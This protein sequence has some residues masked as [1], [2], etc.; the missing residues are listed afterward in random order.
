MRSVSDID[1]VTVDGFGTLLELVDP[2]DALR[3][4]LAR[5]GVERDADAVRQA[6][7]AE[8]GHYR[9]RSLAGRDAAGLAAL[10]EECVGVFLST[11]E[12]DLPPAS[13][14]DAF[15]A[16]I[17]FTLADG[18]GNALEQIAAAGVALA[19][20]AN[21]DSSLHDHLGRSGVAHRFQVV[22]PSAEAGC[23]KPDPRIFA[24]ALERL[25]VEPG[26]AVHIGD[27]ESDRQGAAAAGMRFEPVPLATLP[28]RLGLGR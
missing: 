28:A 26:R 4:A 11:L 25:A 21:W 20:V 3:S 14:V 15:I 12:A 2:V 10:R 1:A 16:S 22:L 13:F 27:E 18:A 7:L 24:I 19:C 6:F 5:R 23:E 8:V 17:E 9:P